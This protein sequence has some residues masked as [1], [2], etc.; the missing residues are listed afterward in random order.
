VKSGDDQLTTAKS[1][2]GSQDEPEDDSDTDEDV[3]ID[4]GPCELYLEQSNPDLISQTIK[5]GNFYPEFDV[6]LGSD[7]RDE[8]HCENDKRPRCNADESE[9]VE[10]TDFQPQDGGKVRVQG[11]QR[12]EVSWPNPEA[13]E[14]AAALRA[15][16]RG[17][18]GQ[19][20]F[21]LDLK[22]LH[23]RPCSGETVLK[24]KD[25]VSDGVDKRLVF[26]LVPD[27][28]QTQP[29]PAIDINLTKDE[30][31]ETRSGVRIEGSS[32][33]ALIQS[34]NP[35]LFP[36]DRDVS[37]LQEKDVEIM[38][39]E[40]T[41]CAYKRGRMIDGSSNLTTTDLLLNMDLD[42]EPSQ[43]SQK[44]I[45]GTSLDSSY[46]N[47][48]PK[49]GSYIVYDISPAV[50]ASKKEDKPEFAGYLDVLFRHLD[51]DALKA[52]ANRECLSKVAQERGHHITVMDQGRLQMDRVNS[53]SLRVPYI[54]KRVRLCLVRAKRPVD[55]NKLESQRTGKFRNP[56]E[57]YVESQYHRLNPIGLQTYPLI[58]GKP[59][60]ETPLPNA[61]VKHWG[62]VDLGTHLRDPRNSTNCDPGH[63]WY[64]EPASVI[65]SL[66]K[67]P[68]VETSILGCSEGDTLPL[69]LGYGNWTEL[70]STILAAKRADNNGK[71]GVGKKGVGKKGVDVDQK[72]GQKAVSVKQ[73]K[74]ILELPNKSPETMN[75]DPVKR[76]RHTVVNDLVRTTDPIY[77]PQIT[78]M[79][80]AFG[81]PSSKSPKHHSSD[82]TLPVN[83]VVPSEKSEGRTSVR[84]TLARH[85]QMIPVGNNVLTEFGATKLYLL[86]EE[87]IIYD[88]CNRRD[89]SRFKILRKIA[90]KIERGAQIEDEEE[91]EEEED[92][93][94]TLEITGGY[95]F[96]MPEKKINKALAASCFSYADL[97]MLEV[98]GGLGS[99]IPRIT[100]ATG[101]KGVAD[102]LMYSPL[103][104]RNDQLTDPDGLSLLS[105]CVNAGNHQTLSMRMT[106]F[107][108]Q[109]LAQKRREFHLDSNTSPQLLSEALSYAKTAPKSDIN[110]MTY[111]TVIESTLEL[112]KDLQTKKIVYT[113]AMCSNMRSGS[114]K[115]SHASNS[116]IGVV[117]ED[118]SNKSQSQA[119]NVRGGERVRFRVAD[120][121]PKSVLQFKPDDEKKMLAEERVL[122]KKLKK[123]SPTEKLDLQRK[124]QQ[125]PFEFH[126][127][128]MG[129]M[130][131]VQPSRWRLQFDEGDKSSFC[132]GRGHIV[133]V[134]ARKDNKRV[135]CMKRYKQ[136]GSFKKDEAANLE[137]YRATRLL[138]RQDWFLESDIQRMVVA[139]KT[140]NLSM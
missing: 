36:L 71:K 9:I 23:S 35:D 51:H 122:R 27:A 138:A 47:G 2:S 76:T 60:R 31:L 126:R 28:E 24:D 48:N 121:H 112:R 81:N 139:G 86:D 106:S 99:L 103:L 130:K 45:R 131:V 64:V 116:A 78:S 34:R 123:A 56:Y 96:L 93:P 120:V 132:V 75:T 72:G 109:D 108:F 129:R 4:D 26:D 59:K 97:K 127:I 1:V 110:V 43:F 13:L 77:Y 104:T 17:N 134:R 66:S 7:D 67:D 119:S 49:R 89:F 137:V 98:L 100:T 80:Q 33:S 105:S 18:R 12:F 133:S 19:K 32:L 85:T 37:H 10:L 102:A 118:V 111:G 92:L 14:Y 22:S 21:E 107:F 82:F 124:I 40:L 117:F 54:Q 11:T 42:F 5:C 88:R 38:E 29:P 90:E 113:N 135:P 69:E 41:S 62:M 44:H 53:E 101:R 6:E 94:S 136:P 50:D 65:A 25:V 114:S 87:E 15:D 84:D 79:Q 58:P 20:S 68:T 125:L 30:L 140:S 3:P 61:L 39:S 91:E 115:E 52:F 70:F 63:F 57:A 16:K 74:E 55:H 95:T 46:G 73:K 8:D 83:P 128:Q